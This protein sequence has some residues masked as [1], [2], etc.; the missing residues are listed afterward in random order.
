MFP[1]GQFWERGGVRKGSPRRGSELC[2]PVVGGRWSVVGGLERHSLELE[3]AAWAA[4]WGVEEFRAS[5]VTVGYEASL[6]SPLTL[7][8][9]TGCV[10]PTQPILQLS[11]RQLGVLPFRYDTS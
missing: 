4:A 11:R 5:S 8:T 3:G 7:L 6:S 2:P 1:A 10:S 9:P